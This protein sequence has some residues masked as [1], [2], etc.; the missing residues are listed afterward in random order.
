MGAA[1]IAPNLQGIHQSTQVLVGDIRV[2]ADDAYLRSSI[3]Q[4]QLQIVKGYA[5]AMPAY[6]HLTDAELDQ[7]VAY[8]KSL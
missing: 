7:L 2:K 8:L 6:A 4:P 1:Q 5:A 3:K